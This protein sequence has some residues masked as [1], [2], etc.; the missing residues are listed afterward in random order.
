GV[1]GVALVAR[2]AYP[3]LGK[4]RVGLF[5]DAPLQPRWVIDAFARVGASEFATVAALAI[6]G[7]GKRV[8]W[9]V[10]A[11]ARLERMVF[12]GA[13]PTEALALAQHVPHER[14]VPAFS[15]ADLAALDLDVA[16][17]I[18]EF[19]HPALAAV[20]RYGL[21]RLCFGADRADPAA[22][23]GFGEVARGEPLSASGLEVRLPGEASRLAHWSW[24]RTFPY[25]VA[26]NRARLLT[27]TGEFIYRALRELQRSG[28][29]WLEQCPRE[30]AP[31]CVRPPPPHPPLL[32]HLATTPIPVL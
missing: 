14:F 19:D 24:S 18:G 28:P 26:R 20:A 12:G 9:P 3:P 5:A 1:A 23:A 6:V 30:E 13:Q 7:G 17:A 27:K 4:L 8:P 25:S 2:V 21:W 32:P 29:G 11:Y 31:A 22:L 10:G 15:G 16:F